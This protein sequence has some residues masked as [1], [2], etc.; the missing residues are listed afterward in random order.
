LAERPELVL[1]EDTADGRLAAGAIAAAC[2]TSPLAGVSEITVK[3]GKV[4][5]ERLVY[6]GAA[7]QT[8]AASGVVVATVSA[9]LYE[10]QGGGACGE[11][12]DLVLEPAVGIKFVG[13][14]VKSASGEDL[15]GEKVVVGV[16]R[17]VGSAD[18]VAAVRR[19]A[20]AIGAGVGATRPA[21]EETDWYDGT[22]YLG[23]SG[24]T[25]RP[26][27]YIACGVSGQVQHMVGVN[28]AGLIFAINKDER[29]TIFGECDYG[30][31]GDANQ[32]VPEL[33]ARFTQA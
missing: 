29:A 31:V 32:V 6:G 18:G 20:A 19:F 27:V 21:A 24:D 1:V 15:S 5:A 12:R 9:G 11:V 10:A 3:D 23:I 7:V 13:R 22:R 8:V 30:I 14:A 33:A 26:D 2:Q 25:I 28:Q 16:G 4:V 17:G